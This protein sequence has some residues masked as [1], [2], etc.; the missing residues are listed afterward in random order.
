[1][2]TVPG[3]RITP[4]NDLPVNVGGSFVL[5]WMTAFRR[6]NWNFSLQRAVEWASELQKPLV[7][8]GSLAL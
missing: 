2:G 3:I 8:S 5:Y 1:M 7:V 6:K 4:A